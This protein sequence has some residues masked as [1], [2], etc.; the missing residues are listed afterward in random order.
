M[1]N[2]GSYLCSAYV[3][4]YSSNNVLEMQIRNGFNSYSAVGK[5]VGELRSDVECFWCVLLEGKRDRYIVYLLPFLFS[6]SFFFPSSEGI[7]ST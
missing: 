7:A 6:F 1:K 2:G 5:G 3:C 4:V